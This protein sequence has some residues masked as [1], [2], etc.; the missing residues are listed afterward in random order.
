MNDINKETQTEFGPINQGSLVEYPF[1]KVL[2]SLAMAQ[3]TGILL[4]SRSKIEKTIYLKDGFIVSASSNQPRDQLGNILVRKNVITEQQLQEATGIY[5]E[6]DGFESYSRIF[7]EMGIIDSERLQSFLRL[8]YLSIIYSLFHWDNG[9]FSFV[10]EEFPEDKNIMQLTSGDLISGG[11][12]SIKS[13]DRLNV[14]LPN[15]NTYLRKTQDPYIR[16]QKIRLNSDEKKILE[17]ITGEQTIADILNLRN[18]Q[19]IDAVK[20]LNSLI[21]TGLLETTD[22]SIDELEIQGVIGAELEEI[23]AYDLSS[24]VEGEDTEM[25]LL[26]DKTKQKEEGDLSH[27]FLPS[28]LVSLAHEKKTGLLICVREEIKKEVY[29]KDGTPIFAKSDSSFEQLIPLLQFAAKLT[30]AQAEE[31]LKIWQ[32]RQNDW[33]GTVLMELGYLDFDDL[34]WPYQFQMKEILVEML[35]WTEGTYAFYD[36]DLPDTLMTIFE[37]SVPEIIIDYVKRNST[38]DAIQNR[39]PASTTVFNKTFTQIEDLKRTPL[40]GSEID[41]L[42][43]VDGKRT[44]SNILESVHLEAPELKELLLIFQLLQ[45]I[46]PV[47]VVPEPE[48]AEVIPE[49]APA[50][51]VPAEKP[52]TPISLSEK[53]LPLTAR[54]RSFHQKMVQF[55]D[56]YQILGLNRDCDNDQIEIKYHLLINEFHPDQTAALQDNET[57]KM[58]QEIIKDV[59]EAYKILKDPELRSLYDGDL[60]HA[61]DIGDE[62]QNKAIEL[63]NEGDQFLSKEDFKQALKKYQEALKDSPQNPDLLAKITFILA[64]SEEKF[65]DAKKICRQAIESDASNPTL[66]ALMASICRCSGLII[67]AKQAIKQAI[68]LDPNNTYALEE[69]RLLKENVKKITAPDRKHFTVLLLENL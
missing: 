34:D 3:L 18:F 48:P 31:A 44:V 26:E 10:A 11:I 62:S 8:H 65:R 69:E 23:I 53:T 6:R 61:I 51:L 16:Y 7:I 13:V 20:A 27:V 25:Q 67:V 33:Q 32:E 59:S 9:D 43:M 19:K 24:S 56:P 55:H 54:I 50:E 42:E 39:L 12:R 37:I 38:A 63:E 49:Q 57:I 36:G 35:S 22:S 28:Y 45:Y 30:G 29:I 2:H 58:A 21:Y 47:D 15:S 66:H 60:E 41:L 46:T 17:M 64:F 14:L 40:T 4:L 68:N 5:E 52:V 1:P